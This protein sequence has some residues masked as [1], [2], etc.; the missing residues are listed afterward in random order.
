MYGDYCNYGY[1][2]ALANVIAK[3]INWATDIVQSY[4]LGELK[5]FFSNNTIAADLTY[6]LF[7]EEYS[8]VETIKYCKALCIYLFKQL[9]S[10]SQLKLSVADQ[11][12]AF[13]NALNDFMLSNYITC[14]RTQFEYAYYGETCPLK[15]KTEYFEIF[16]ADGHFIDFDNDEY[17]VF[18]LVG[19]DNISKSLTTLN[20]EANDLIERFSL[21][22]VVE[23]VTVY[24]HTTDSS[25]SVYGKEYINFCYPNRREI[26]VT[27]L[28]AFLHEYSHYIEYLL[29]SVSGSRQG[30]QSQAFAELCGTYSYYQHRYYYTA[31]NTAIG[32]EF[33]HACYGRDYVFGREGIFLY[34]DATCY[35]LD[36]YEL[37]YNATREQINSFS[38]YLLDIYGE[39][40]V[41]YLM[42]FPENV[43]TITG[44]SWNTLKNEWEVKIKETFT[45][46]EYHIN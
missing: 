44:K 13:Y 20:N 37:N 39:S 4:S 33:F 2:Y 21:E 3:E 1:L 6:P 31:A 8:S 17:E 11:L 19:Y 24:M 42:L 12:N 14:S 46:V 5:N 16:L 38:Y 36:N 45:G 15:V 25:R 7:L 34:S 32:S 23:R 26:E 10:Q 18:D 30:W 29:N 40:T 27:F 22:N 35:V 28:H 43:I 9:N 41:C